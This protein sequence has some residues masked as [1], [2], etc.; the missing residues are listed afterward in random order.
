MSRREWD[1]SAIMARVKAGSITLVEATPLLGISYRQGKRLYARYK[2]RGAS[3]LVH[4][5]AGRVSNRSHPL[6]EREMVIWPGG[7][8]SIV[9]G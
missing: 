1:R 9:A 2:A 5:S 4:A 7:G 3:G 6:A 8:L